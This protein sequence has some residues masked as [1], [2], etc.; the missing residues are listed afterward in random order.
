M[1]LLEREI[2]ELREWIVVKNALLRKINLGVRLRSEAS[3]EA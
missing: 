1:L 2:P 3:I